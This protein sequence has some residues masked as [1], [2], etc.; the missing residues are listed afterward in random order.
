MTRWNRQT[1]G[2]GS[3]SRGDRCGTQRDRGRTDSAYVTS[4]AMLT[5]STSFGPTCRLASSP[6]VGPGATVGTLKQRYPLLQCEG[7]V[8]MRLPLV[9]W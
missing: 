7:A 6:K 9:A 2:R 8:P 4:H 3:V 5:R 1:W